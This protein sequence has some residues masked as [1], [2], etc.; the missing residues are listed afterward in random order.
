MLG[1]FFSTYFVNFFFYY[2]FTSFTSIATGSDLFIS[3]L[4]VD[5]YKMVCTENDTSL[6]ITIPVV[7]I[8]KSAGESMK[9]SLSTGGKGELH[10]HIL[11]F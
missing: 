7:M 3:S 5:L 8:P 11:S 9:D 4:F 2:G 1:L 6:N 10:V